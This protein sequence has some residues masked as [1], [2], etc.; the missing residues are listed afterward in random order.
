MRSQSRAQSR[1]PML[2]TATWFSSSTTQTP[3]YRCSAG[4]GSPSETAGIPAAGRCPWPPS[5]GVSYPVAFPIDHRSASGSW[6]H[7][8][9]ARTMKASNIGTVKAVC[10]WAGLQIMPFLIKP[11]RNGPALCTLIP[12]T[13]AISPDRWGPAPSD[14]MARR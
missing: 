4:D 6:P 7:S 5:S 1:P 3:A 11:L 12:N 13:S 8:G 9:I 14:A 10:P 2:S